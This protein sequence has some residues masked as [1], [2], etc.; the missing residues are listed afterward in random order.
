MLDCSMGFYLSPTHWQRIRQSA[1]FYRIDLLMSE[2]N[3]DV[4]IHVISIRVSEVCE[5]LLLLDSSFEA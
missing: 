3:L 2:S 4:N 1:V 5:R